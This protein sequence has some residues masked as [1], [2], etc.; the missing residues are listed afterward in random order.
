[1]RAWKNTQD[2]N[3][4]QA[5]VLF[6]LD[7]A[8]RQGSGPSETMKSLWLSQKMKEIRDL[9][10]RATRLACSAKRKGSSVRTTIQLSPSMKALGGVH[11]KFLEVT[12]KAERNPNRTYTVLNQNM[13][14]VY[15]I[16]LD[17]KAAI[18]AMFHLGGHTKC[19]ALHIDVLKAVIPGLM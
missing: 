10:S 18:A 5:D 3:R 13:L 12:K 1:M 11:A 14:T 15:D 19:W 8:S 2:N 4:A 16:M 17:G 7:I 6:G 9:E